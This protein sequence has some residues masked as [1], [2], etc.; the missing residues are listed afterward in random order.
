MRPTIL[1]WARA[2]A[3][4]LVSV[5]G[6]VETRVRGICLLVSLRLLVSIDPVDDKFALGAEIRS[7]WRLLALATDDA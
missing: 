5:R 1:S 3:I 2:L 6:L 4:L 7:S